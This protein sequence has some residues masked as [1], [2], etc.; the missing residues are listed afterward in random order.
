MSNCI[1]NVSDFFSC[2]KKAAWDKDISGMIALY[3]ETVTIFDMWGDKGFCSGLVD[4]SVEITDWLSSLGD[5]KVEVS[6]EMI[7][8]QESEPIAFA[9]ALI[10]FQAISTNKEVLRSMKNRITLDF[11][12]VEDLWKVRHQHISAPIDSD[13]SAILDI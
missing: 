2:Y 11:V 7:E 5:E 10:Q 1:V 4:W 13:L 3:D 12:K 9:S 6:F 8:I